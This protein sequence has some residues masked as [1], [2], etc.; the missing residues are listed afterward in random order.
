M[1][2]S[3]SVPRGVRIVTTSPA[4]AFKSTVAIGEIHETPQRWDRSRCRHRLRNV[5][6]R[7]ATKGGALSRLQLRP[8]PLPLRASGNGGCFN[9]AMTAVSTV[10]SPFS[11]AC[12]RSSRQRVRF[13]VVPPGPQF[14]N[15]I[16]SSV[17]FVSTTN[18]ARSWAGCVSLALALTR[19]RSPGSSE[20][21]CPAL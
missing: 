10:P 9:E 19:W 2:S 13:M 8:F 5:F 3:S 6:C 4:C 7:A 1:I 11:S 16:V 18:T 21:L 14:P 20:K 12:Q 15:G 17:S